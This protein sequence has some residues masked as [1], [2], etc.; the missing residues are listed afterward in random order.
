MVFPFKKYALQKPVWVLMVVLII[1]F[2]TS[3]QAGFYDLPEITETPDLK[4]KSLL[5][6]MD[7]PNVRERDPD[8]E[9]GPH[10]SISE[11][12][13]QGIV[14]F[15]E[16]GIT[17]AE[18][19]K[20]VEDIR[21]DMM[22][23]EKILESGYTLEELGDVSDLL[24]EI[25]DETIG[26]HVTSLD[27]QKL[28]WLVRE[29]R[30]NRGIT[31]GMIETIADTITNYYRERGFIL[32]KA[33]IPEQ[34]VRDGVVTLTLLLGTLGEIVVNNN[35]LYSEESLSSVF[36]SVL[37]KPITSSFIEERLYLINDFPG[38]TAQG[39]FEPGSQV[40]DT[41]LNINVKSR[42][43]ELGYEIRCVKPIAF[44]LMYCA[45][46]GMGV[47]RLFDKG[48]TGCMVTADAKGDISPL[49]LKDVTDEHGKVKPRLVNINSQKALIVFEDGLQYLTEIDYEAAKQYVDEPE[50]YDFRKILNW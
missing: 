49:Y 23:E 38:I 22:G 11:F 42:P 25:E 3:V 37:A 24:G 27:V 5:R 34:E 32:A 28:V 2:H 14:E 48:I 44:D 43:V 16:L 19:S 39:F 45:L 1:G 41:K 13:L 15:P 12:R 26:R 40:G 17:R 9:G 33:Y 29:Q 7:I 18:I 6:D 35:Q 8:P 21:F 30:Q 36:D 20:M 31:L 50:K 47:K 46:L 10:L 4:R